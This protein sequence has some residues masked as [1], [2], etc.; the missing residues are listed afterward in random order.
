MPDPYGAF[1][2]RRSQD[3]ST[4]NNAIVL[5]Q[6]QLAQM[7]QIAFGRALQSLFGGGA[8]QAPMPGQ[9]SQPMGPPPGPQGPGF[10]NPIPPGVAGP[11]PGPQGPMMPPGA[12]PM[13]GAPSAPASGPPTGP[14][15][16]S[17][18]AGGPPG[19]GDPPQLDMR[20]VAQMIAR[21]NPGAP[22]AVLAAAMDA[23]MPMMNAQAQADWHEQR[24]ALQ[25]QQIE[26]NLTTRTQ[27]LEERGRQFDTREERLRKE[28]EERERRIR[29]NFDRREQRLSNPT[30]RTGRGGTGGTRWSIFADWKKEFVEKNGRE[31]TAAEQNEFYQ[32]TAAGAP[33]RADKAQAANNLLDAANEQIDQAIDTALSAKE[34]GPAVTGLMG[35]IERGKEFV[36]NMFGFSDEA[37]ARQFESR[38]TRLKNVVPRLMAST[39]RI[40]KEERAELDTIVRGLGAM[41]DPRAV[42]D[43]LQDLKI[44]LN[45]IHGR[46]MPGGTRPAEPAPRPTPTDP[47][48]GV[49][50]PPMPPA[51]R[52]K[53]DEA[54][55][56][57]HSRVEVEA[58]IRKMGFDPAR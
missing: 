39:S 32:S 47:N 31:P 15:G 46:A 51:I 9:P 25:H 28:Y 21:A 23:A 55:A 56:A 54:L 22:P 40:S 4:D 53:Y 16:P 14:Q 57:G 48:P 52:A 3:I 17:A 10:G 41:S 5:Q 43:S 18:P 30:L 45:K 24:L 6:R 37:T 11:P 19:G 44:M 38:I 36:G 58:R 27:A 50:L 49:T 33:G 35:R 34:G 26:N 1:A 29:E 42:A 7:G 20:T 2:E 13:P 12:T 8:P